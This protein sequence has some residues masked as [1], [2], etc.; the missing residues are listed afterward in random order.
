MILEDDK[1]CF[2][3]GQDNP[4]G[5]KLKIERGDKKA[6]IKYTPDKTLQGYKDIVHGGIL[7]TLMDEAMAHAVASMGLMGVTAKLEIKFKK[8][9]EVGNTITIEGTVEDVRNGWAYTNSKIMSDKHEI[10][11]EAKG[12]FKILQV[13]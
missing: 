13:K 4:R 10:L 3:C 9:V 7:A 6:V 5:L 1:Y 8:P 12:L 2:A 11:A